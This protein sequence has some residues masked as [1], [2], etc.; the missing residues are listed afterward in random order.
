MENY[1]NDNSKNY[2]SNTE[3]TAWHQAVD[4]QER[5]ENRFYNESIKHTFSTIISFSISLVSAYL[6]TPAWESSDWRASLISLCGAVITSADV[7]M[8]AMS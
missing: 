8:T 6:Y 2:K 1:Y 5:I 3:I 7:M 4:I